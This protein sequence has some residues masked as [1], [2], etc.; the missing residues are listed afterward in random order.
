[1]FRA[2]GDVLEWLHGSPGVGE[3]EMAH[4]A[5]KHQHPL[6]LGQLPSEA[7]APAAAEGEVR[8]RGGHA[9]CGRSFGIEAALLGPKGIGVQHQALLGG[10]AHAADLQ[11]RV[12]P[13]SQCGHGREDPESLIEGALREP[14]VV[15]RVHVGQVSRLCLV[16]HSVLDLGVAREQQESPREGVRGSLVPGYEKAKQFAHDLL[17]IKLCAIFIREVHGAAQHRRL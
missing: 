11:L 4:Q 14:Q 16:C 12:V 10:D 13:A 5:C 1:M 6:Q 8:L 15:E 17:V 9:A 2:E 7:G 3:A